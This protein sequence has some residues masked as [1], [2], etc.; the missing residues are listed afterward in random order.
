VIFHVRPYAA[1]FWVSA[2]REARI[3]P[4]LHVVVFGPVFE[5]FG[6]KPPLAQRQQVFLLTSKSHAT[7]STPIRAESGRESRFAA[8]GGGVVDLCAMLFSLGCHGAR[9]DPLKHGG[10]VRYRFKLSPTGKCSVWFGMEKL[11]IFV[12]LR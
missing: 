10:M 6:S 2:A 7:A 11:N 12:C 4:T 8:E 9:C 5:G 3:S 1:L